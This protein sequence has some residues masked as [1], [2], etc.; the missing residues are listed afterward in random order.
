MKRKTHS[1][2]ENCKFEDL[3]IGD[4]FKLFDPD[5]SPVI[6]D[7]YCIAASEPYETDGVMGINADVIRNEGAVQCT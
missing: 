4:I 5:G 2:W 6:D 7:G 1:R 3:K